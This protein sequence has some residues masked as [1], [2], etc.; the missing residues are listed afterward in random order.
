MVIY[1]HIWC[2]YTVLAN[3]TH[4]CSCV[5]GLSGPNFEILLFLHTLA[6]LCY[7]HA[8][9]THCDEVAVAHRESR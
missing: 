5:F 1:G 8:S 9:R 7:W 3:P 2:I 6:C 4:R